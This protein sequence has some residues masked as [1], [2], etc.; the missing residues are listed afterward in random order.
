MNMCVG[1][2]AS[3]G[4]RVPIHRNRPSVEHCWPF[5]KKREEKPFFFLCPEFPARY[6]NRLNDR[7]KKKSPIQKVFL[8]TENEGNCFCHSHQS[9][10]PAV[11]LCDGFGQSAALSA[12]WR[13][14]RFN[15]R[16]P[17][18]IVLHFRT[19]ADRMIGSLVTAAFVVDQ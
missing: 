18:P 16:S 4:I 17:L 13:S 8:I 14:R 6:N 15:N 9:L 10:P 7:T 5:S 12:F 1:E 2:W 19:P 11:L 3:T